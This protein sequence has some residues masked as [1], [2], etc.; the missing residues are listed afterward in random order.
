[1]VGFGIILWWTIS[2]LSRLSA[3]TLTPA[4]QE[5]SLLGQLAGSAT[6][7]PTP[8]FPPTSTPTLAVGPQILDRV[9]LYIDIKQRSWVR[10][11]VD[12]QVAFEGQ[13]EPG[14][15][16]R[17]EGL[18]SIRVLAGNGAGLIVTYNGLQIG[19]LGERGEVVERIFTPSEQITPTATPTVT[20][21]STSVP[22]PTPR[23]SATPTPR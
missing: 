21:T 2:Q 22:T 17:Y 18:Q 9:L 8:T 13:A 6:F 23:V 7:E 1:L 11:I 5:V 4:T 12:G 15:V 3:E 19:P 14:M 10:I 20:P 16:L